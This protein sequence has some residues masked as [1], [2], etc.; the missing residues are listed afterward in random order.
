MF[1]RRAKYDALRAEYEQTVQQLAET[2]EQLADWKGSAIR[3]AG[4]NGELQRRLD[5]SRDVAFL[6]NEFVGQLESRLARVLRACARYRAELSDEVAAHAKTI[7]NFEAYVEV[8]AE[9]PLDMFEERRS[10]RLAERA[11]RSLDA[12]IKPLQA[13]NEAMAA[14]LRDLREGSE[15]RA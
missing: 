10:R 2:G 3:V 15:A 12:Q 13:A 8:A 1:V 14:E 4:R 5:A 11:H 7:D 9:V 6:D